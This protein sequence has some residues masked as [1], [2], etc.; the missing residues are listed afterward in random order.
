LVLIIITINYYGYTIFVIYI[1]LV[2]LYTDMDMVLAVDPSKW[3]DEDKSLL[4]YI[5]DKFE[6]YLFLYLYVE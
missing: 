4:Y 2:F 5:C 3:T 1:Y 6:I